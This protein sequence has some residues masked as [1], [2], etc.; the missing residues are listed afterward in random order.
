MIIPVIGEQISYLRAKKRMT[1]EDLAL[2][3]G[4]S[5]QTISNWETGLKTPRMGAIQKLA[6]FFGVSKSYIIEGKTISTIETIYNQLDEPRQTKVYSF[7]EEQLE[8]QQN[9]KVV[10][11]V[12]QAAANPNAMTY[13]DTVY[14]EYSEKNA[15]TNADY[16]IIVKGDSM[17]PCFANKSTVYYHKQ[18]IVE[19]GEL[20]I[21]EIDGVEV[22]FKKVMFDHDNE[23]IIL[24]SLNK[25][26]DDRILDS[27]RVKIVGKVVQ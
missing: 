17:E 22:M 8:E 18:E 7:A 14:D 11:I 6:D 24:R 21:V 13:G 20:A 5:K 4:Y 12:G 9:A 23:K 27:S 1:Q 26:Y 3:V 2:Q 25:S 16:A 15:P 10:P 19:N